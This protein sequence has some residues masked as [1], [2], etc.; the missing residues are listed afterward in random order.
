VDCANRSAARVALTEAL[1]GA[2]EGG[3][4]F[5][6]KI[7]GSLVFIVFP[8]FFIRVFVYFSF[9]AGG[10]VLFITVGL[11]FNNAG[12]V[13]SQ[14]NAIKPQDCTRQQPIWAIVMNVTEWSYSS[15]PKNNN[16]A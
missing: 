16:I 9:L 13:L 6:W 12:G 11:I 1:L 8:F 14:S 7:M 4:G 2:V 3:D 15:Y 5:Y 10:W